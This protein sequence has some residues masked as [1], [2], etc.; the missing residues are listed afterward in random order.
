VFSHQ[1]QQRIDT[2][3]IGVPVLAVEHPSHYSMASSATT[4]QE[5]TAAPGLR[6]NEPNNWKREPLPH[7]FAAGFDFFSAQ[8]GRASHRH[9]GLSGD[10]EHQA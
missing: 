10:V 3:Q 8:F 6:S 1:A 5:T 7:R 9:V 2:L 4:L